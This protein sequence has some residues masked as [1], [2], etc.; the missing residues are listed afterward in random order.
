MLQSSAQSLIVGNWKMYKTIAETRA[1]IHQLLP[2]ID[3]G[4]AR[5][6]LAVPFTAINAAVQAAK[7]SPI[8]VGA[9]N[10]GIAE[11]GAFTG[12]ISCRMLKEAGAAFVIVGHSE[13]RQLYGE[14]DTIVNQ[15]TL[16]V[17]KEGLMP[18]VC[19][20]ETAE[21]R[22][23][24]H[25]KNVLGAQLSRSLAEV[26]AEDFTRLKIAYEPIWAIGT[27]LT[28]TPEQ[29]QE[30]HHFCRLEIERQWGQVAADGVEILYGGSVKP[31]N[32][33]SLLV[34][35]DINGLLVGGSSLTVESFSQIVND[36]HI[37]AS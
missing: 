1:Y 18:I 13:R 22:K 12:E 15:K 4:L 14:D 27:N 19:I 37:N 9:Q 26:S 30:M 2:L 6:W 34:Q 33:A 29:A 23:Q 8:V 28:A 36:Q 5:A 31:E 25:A 7:S 11:E 17:L 21:Q 32:A 16:R 35:P 10:V 20:G 3:K 24:G